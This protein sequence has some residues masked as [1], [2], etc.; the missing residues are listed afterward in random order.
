MFS[1]KQALKQ[2]MYIH[3]GEK[4]WKCTHPGCGKSFAQQSAHSKLAFSVLLQITN[5]LKRD[6]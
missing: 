1:A 2:H 3:T 5:K 4:P 6:A